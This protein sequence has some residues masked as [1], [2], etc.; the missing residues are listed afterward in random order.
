M[1]YFKN[2]GKNVTWKTG[3]QKLFYFLTS[4]NY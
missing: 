3:N 4:P 1:S 2:F